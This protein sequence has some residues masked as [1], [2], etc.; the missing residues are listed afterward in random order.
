MAYLG[1]K[2]ASLAGDATVA[3]GSVTTAKIANGAITTEKIA[4]GAVVQADLASGVAGTGPA[5][6]AWAST[7]TN[8]A[9][10]TF[11][12]LIFATEEFDTNNNF[13]S[14]TFTPTVAGYYL[15]SG[16]TSNSVNTVIVSVF[17]N[18]TEYK[19]GSQSLGATL[20]LVN[21]SAL[22]YLNGSTDYVELYWYQA[23]GATQNSAI[24]SSVS[25]FQGT[26]VRSA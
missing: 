22:V 1:F 9:T 18:G 15:I 13:A 12:K 5:F 3:D 25:Y 19:R 17:K 6:S 10:A 20:S 7:A 16:A 24:G 14:S 2:P 23:S 11:T 8:T 4:N 26:L 21:V